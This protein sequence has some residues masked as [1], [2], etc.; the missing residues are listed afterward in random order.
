[1]VERLLALDDADATF[2]RGFSDLRLKNWN[3]LE[4]GQLRAAPA[5]GAGWAGPQ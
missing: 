3:G 1:V 5:L 2:V 4:V